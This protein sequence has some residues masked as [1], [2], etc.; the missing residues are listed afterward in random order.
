MTAYRAVR[1]Q[2]PD[3]PGA[4]SAISAALAAH[5][6]DIVQLDV[7][8]H[9]GETVVDDLLLA[10]GSAHDI[11][12]AIG[13]FHPDVFVRTFDSIAGDPALEM[14]R[15]L[16]EVAASTSLSEGRV[17][18]R[19]AAA[20]IARAESAILMR[21][22]DAGGFEMLG[23]G[24][25]APAIE[26]LEPFAGRW[27][28]EHRTAAAFPVSDGWAP[29]RFQH[30][31]GAAWIGLAPADAFTLVLAMRKL[32]IPFFAGELERFA[33]F[34]QAAGTIMASAGDRPPF[35]ALP[36]PSGTVLPPRAVTL[37]PRLPLGQG[38]T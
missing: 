30:A 35:S 3:R 31:L 19:L 37:A 18:A 7:V 25:G 17:A 9:E 26:P 10:A 27:V 11:G 21:L 23:P 5:R 8:S 38:A 14:G 28:L 33:A 16:A 32:N 34:S 12:A 29:Q 1:I 24:V 20:R 4:L 6:V 36:P 15:G 2:M 22:T 13:G